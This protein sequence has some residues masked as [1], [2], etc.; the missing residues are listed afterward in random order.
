MLNHL[1]QLIFG[2]SPINPSGVLRW[3]RE[4]LQSALDAARADTLAEDA[5]NRAS[6]RH[7]RHNRIIIAQGGDFQ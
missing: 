3:D 1:R 4:R 7:T 6:M 5:Q 2:H